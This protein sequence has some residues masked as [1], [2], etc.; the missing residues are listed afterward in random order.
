MKYII[1][2]TLRDIRETIGSF[3]SILI[4]IFIGCFFFAGV[5]EGSGT[6]SAQ[7]SD[8]YESQNYS[9]YRAEYMYVNEPAIEEM[10][11]VEGV[12]AARGCDTF[13]TKT[14]ADGIR[15]DMTLTTLTDGIDEPYMLRGKLP[16]PGANEL[17]IDSVFSDE[18]GVDVGDTLD[19]T[20]ATLKKI[21]LELQGEDQS[22]P[23]YSMEYDN[24]DYSFKVSGVFHSPDV[25]YKVNVMN[26]AARPEEFILAYTT[27]GAVKSYTD[28]AVVVT[29]QKFGSTVIEMKLLKYADVSVNI[30]NGVR[31]I[32]Y[33]ENAEKMFKKHSVPET[34]DEEEEK[35][36]T[37]EEWVKNILFKDKSAPAGLFMYSTEQKNFPS[38]TAFDG[39]NDTISSLAAVLPMIFFAVAAAITV[40]SLSKTVENQRMQIGIMQ[41]LG[42]GKSRV[43]FSYLFYALF[44]SVVGGLAGGAVGT[45]L[46]PFLLNLIYARQFTLPPTPQSLNFIYM[47]IGVLISAAL[48]CLSAFISCYRTLKDVPAQA[49]RPKPPKKTKRILVERWTGLWKRLGFGAKMNLRNMFLHKMRMILSSVGIVGCLALLI[50][51][52]GLKDNMS[53]SFTSYDRSTGYD[54]T[55]VSDVAVDL[56]DEGVYA[57]ID[58]ADG[59]EY[60]HN[61][62]FVPDFAGKLELKKDGTVK[63]EDITVMALPTYADEKSYRYA[64]ADCVRLY[65]DLAGKDRVLFENDTFVIPEMIAEKLGA[66]AGDVIRVTGY[67]LD[68]RPID[69]E[70]EITAVVCEYFDQKAY[71]SYA[72]F[73]DNGVGLYADK[74]YAT[75]LPGVD[76]DVAIDSLKNNE[77]V[78]D[79]KTFRE[80]FEALEK[81]MSL[82]D[83]AVII[84]VVGAA[85]L[86]VAVIYNITATNL[87]ERTR[88][89]ATLMVLGYKRNETANMVIVE[90]MVITAIG[91]IL[92]LPLG[93]GLMLWVVDITKSFS[94][95]ISSFLSW[96]VAIGCVALTFVFSLL[97]TMLLNTKMKKI[98]M[99]EALKSIE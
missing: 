6:I 13:Y 2:K 11:S 26:T 86:A 72:V 94:V 62:T 60:M 69:F 4:V 49:M 52:V 20:V 50:G 22:T 93:Y 73:K 84:F 8:Y 38:V 96:Y 47:F 34:D 64:D 87:K 66:K 99:V 77:V 59:E 1:L 90:N 95:F 37:A 32:G 46:I 70:I 91:C 23:K 83:Y 16:E 42:V 39:I 33:P 75:L 43:Y 51:L 28:D 82:L 35:G 74:S 14:K 31:I 65:T 30:Y 17:I 98:S 24:I 7:V 55:I 57:E 15:Y 53:F 63:S 9:T 67:S 48:A 19:F 89:I 12:T 5:A 92:G 45:F 88:E 58:G 68:N 78:R 25:I 10:R 29:P 97:A 85:V 36:V 44:A 56:N 41:A 40:I 21:S 71:C 81:Q 79:V 54:M 61:L 76:M 3:I 18:H 27:Y 80:S